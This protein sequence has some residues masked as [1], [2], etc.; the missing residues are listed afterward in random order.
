MATTERAAE[1][2]SRERVAAVALGGLVVAGV[3]AVVIAYLSRP[4]QMGAD[5]DV[6]RTVDALYTAVRLKDEGKL[7]Q[8]EGRLREY[9]ALGKL[10]A[11]PADHLDG[12]IAT[13]RGGDWDRAAERLY[14]FMAAQRREGAEAVADDH[15]PKGK[16]R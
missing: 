10:P 16:G 3:V 15:R 1:G 11:G 7:G 8:C 9:R 6:F 13:A 14:E 12:V 2:V 5:P 4:P